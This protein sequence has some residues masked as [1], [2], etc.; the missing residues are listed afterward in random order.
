MN[1]QY[2]LKL[3]KDL[4]NTKFTIFEYKAELTIESNSKPNIFNTNV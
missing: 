2:V 1:F 4:D 3:K